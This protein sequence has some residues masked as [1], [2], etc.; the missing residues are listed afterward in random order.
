M[1]ES[2]QKAL[3]NIKH[4]QQ[5]IAALSIIFIILYLVI[6][7]YLASDLYKV[8]SS[9]GGIREMLFFILTWPKILIF[10]I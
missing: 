10:A 6:G 1:I 2:E 7:C 5:A 8:L 3:H 9:H 4:S